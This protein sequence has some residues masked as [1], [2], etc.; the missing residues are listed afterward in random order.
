[1]QLAVARDGTVGGTYFN[2]DGDITLPIQGSVDQETRRVAWKVGEEDAVVM[3]TGLENMTKDQA[4]IMLF[5]EGNI[6][7]TWTMIRLDDEAAKTV[8][9]DVAADG[10]R[11]QLAA[12]F[13]RLAATLGDDWK[14]FLA[15]PDEIFSGGDP[16]SLEAV[17][18]ALKH[19]DVIAS[20]N[21]YRTIAERPDFQPTH[22]LLQQYAAELAK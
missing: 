15:L 6:T 1:M 22:Q 13:D 5:F 12:S 10:L 11:S 19:Y 3:E 16:P 21:S 2:S 18:K 4:P 20:D 17:Q 9:A 14:K 8:Q 7:E